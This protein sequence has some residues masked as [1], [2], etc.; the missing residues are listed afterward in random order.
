MQADLVSNGAMDTGNAID[1]AELGMTFSIGEATKIG[2]AYTNMRDTYGT[3]IV[4]A[5]VP[6]VP[7][8]KAVPMVPAVYEW[9]HDTNDATAKVVV[10]RIMAWVQ[11]EASPSTNYEVITAADG[12]TSLRMTSDG[13]TA[14]Q[15]NASTATA[16]RHG[17]F[18]AAQCDGFANDTTDDNECIQVAAYVRTVTTDNTGDGGTSSDDYTYTATADVKT[19]A[20]PAVPGKD[21]VPAVPAVMGR[22]VTKAGHKSTHVAVQHSLG[23][24]TAHL[25]YSQTK[26]NGSAGKSKSV[27]YGVAGGLGDSGM[28]F[29]VQARSDKDAMGNS[30]NPWQANVSRSLGGGATVIFEHGDEDDGNSGKSALMLH[31]NF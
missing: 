5:A 1:K 31:V 24:L 7:A 30:S 2:V 18:T 4:K 25:G 29:V 10:E 23:G 8:V 22:T 12:S 14:M 20:V 3:G 6:M 21:A 17:A 26:V 27:H 13:I 19:E 9:D 28:N 15:G 16:D 11:Q